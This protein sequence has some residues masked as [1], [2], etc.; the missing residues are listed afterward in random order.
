MFLLGRRTA[1]AT[2]LNPAIDY[3][4]VFSRISHG[5]LVSQEST[6]KPPFPY[7]HPTEPYSHNAPDMDSVPSR[8][9]H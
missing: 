2:S 7:V 9:F 8:R 4:T 3:Y 6:A 5:W 1:V